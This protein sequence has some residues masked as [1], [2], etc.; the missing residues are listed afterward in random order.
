MLHRYMNDPLIKRHSTRKTGKRREKRKSEGSSLPSLWLPL[1]VFPVKAKGPP[2]GPLGKE[3]EPGPPP[4]TLVFLGPAPIPL[5]LKYRGGERV[6]P[7]PPPAHSS[8]QSAVWQKDFKLHDSCGQLSPAPPPAHACP[9]PLSS[10][11]EPFPNCSEFAF[12]PSLAPFLLSSF[13]FSSLSS[14]VVPSNFPHLID[15]CDLIRFPPMR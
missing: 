1:S 12:S 9:L 8:C 13:L 15:L 3:P 5:P 11:P 10:L 4:S 7:S 2:S 14:F 6:E